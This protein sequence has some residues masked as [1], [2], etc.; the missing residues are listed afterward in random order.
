MARVQQ[1]VIPIIGQLIA[2]SPG[3][4]SLG[5]GIVH[6]QAP[7]AVPACLADLPDH[8]NRYGDVCGTPELL[9]QIR[10]KL[11][12]E[13]GLT[14][15]E[16]EGA[17]LVTAG[18]NMGFVNAILA[19][20]DLGDEIII[21]SPYYF[22]HHM[23]IEMLGCRPVLA[24]T[25]ADFQLDLEAIRAAITPRTRA[26]VTISPNNPTGAVYREDDL[27][28]VNALCAR[29][30]LFHISDEAYEY[31]HYASSQHFSP[32]RLPGAE[33]YTISL[34]SLS[35]AYGMAGYRIGYM[36]V[37][38][39]LLQP[40]KKAQD[41]NL[42]CPPL[43]SQQAGLAAL[44]EGRTWCRPRV[45]ELAQVRAMV[46]QE[47][48]QIGEFCQVPTPMGAFYMLLNIATQQ[49]DMQLVEALIRDHRV[50]LL[51]GSAFGASFENGCCLR[52][53][54]GALAP[55]TVQDG[56]ERLLHGLRNMR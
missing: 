39:R 47:L 37:P 40:I 25:T 41:T 46:L 44:R 10:H 23:A 56:I 29:H 9:S 7:A 22:N 48:E 24:A 33:Q 16:R 5:Q 55:A 50:A 35:K 45:Q 27:R 54:Y 30:G 31:F 19:I 12:T 13:N 8:L 3:T 20:A 2:Q 15:D 17:V 11:S 6:Y 32:G 53:A 36:H 42:V 51:P 52:L 43:I 1:P 28:E 4:I 49:S 21:Q 14:S 18:S 38:Q 34:F 26:I